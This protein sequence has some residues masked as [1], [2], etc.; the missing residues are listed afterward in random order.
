MCLWRDSSPGY[1]RYPA[2]FFN[3]ETFRFYPEVVSEYNK[4][5][6][7]DLARKPRRK[8]ESLPETHSPELQ[9]RHQGNFPKLP[10]FVWGWCDSRPVLS[11][12]WISQNVED[13]YLPEHGSLVPLIFIKDSFF[14]LR[15]L[16]IILEQGLTGFISLTSQ[17]KQGAS[18][19]KA[20]KM[21][22]A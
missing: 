2:I 10:F 1:H 4:P 7:G 6:P 17:L 20:S 3:S 21:F 18:I 11:L 13:H 16:L 9:V 5:L 12:P 22:A 8:A 15:S 14:F 19:F